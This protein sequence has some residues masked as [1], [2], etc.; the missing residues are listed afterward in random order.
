MFQ[1]IEDFFSSEVT[2]LV[3]DAPEWK[4]DRVNRSV[5]TNTGTSLQNTTSVQQANCN[6]SVLGIF[7]PSPGTPVSYTTYSP[8]SVDDT[9]N[10][11]AGTIAV[12]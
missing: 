10:K 2:T 9:G 8:L 12:S 7:S 1:T 4:L 3:S 11:K 6:N 5:S